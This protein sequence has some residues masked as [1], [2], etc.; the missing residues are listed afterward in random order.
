MLVKLL[1]NLFTASLQNCITYK[2][3]YSKYLDVAN[4]KIIGDK[5]FKCRSIL[6]K[7]SYTQPKLRSAI[8]IDLIV[9]PSDRLSNHF[10]NLFLIYWIGSFTL[11]VLKYRSCF[12]V[13]FF[14]INSMFFLL[15]YYI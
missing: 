13:S 12:S 8:Q 2:K 1:A 10:Q 3:I 4:L 7:I 14:Q 11:Q 15:Q 5:T 9:M 6:K